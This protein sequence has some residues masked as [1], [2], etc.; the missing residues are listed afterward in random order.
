MCVC[1]VY[2]CACKY[3]VLCIHMYL[4]STSRQSP[5][6]CYSCNDILLQLS[7]PFPIPLFSSLPFPSFPY[8]P[9]LSFFHSLPLF[10]SI[11][12]LPLS[13]I[14][15]RCCSRRLTW[16]HVVCMCVGIP[17]PRLG[18]PSPSLRRPAVLGVCIGGRRSCLG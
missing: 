17:P 4:C 10:L 14:C 13:R 15:I 7:S 6:S 12:L 18:S 9:P 5:S 16:L 2:M 3:I 11:Y 8:P 1:V